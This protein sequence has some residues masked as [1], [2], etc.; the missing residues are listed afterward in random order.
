MLGRRRVLA[1][2]AA[3]YGAL[4]SGCGKEGALS[5]P[6][7]HL[8]GSVTI[9]GHPVPSD[10]DESS[11]DFIPA[12]GGGQAHPCSAKIEN[13]KYDA[14]NVP[15]GKVTVIFHVKKLTGRMIREAAGGSLFPEMED[16]VPVQA[17]QGIKIDVAGDA[18]KDFKL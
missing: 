3:L 6:T 7:A 18:Q 9:N 11:M 14:P 15:Q 5:K 1:V 12:G 8:T 2:F 10:A 4:Q 16:L 13:G 17:Q